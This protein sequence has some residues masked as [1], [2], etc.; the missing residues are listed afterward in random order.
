[1]PLPSRIRL[2]I[3]CSSTTVDEVLTVV[4]GSSVEEKDGE[5]EEAI[6]E[7]DG[8]DEAWVLVVTAEIPQTEPPQPSLEDVSLFGSSSPAAPPQACAIEEPQRRLVKVDL[9]GA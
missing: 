7:S 5:E 1:M 9:Y 3:C 8:Q 4:C 2:C 6:G